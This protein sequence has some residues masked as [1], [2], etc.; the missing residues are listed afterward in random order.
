V[1][2]LFALALYAGRVIPVALAH[3]DR[4]NPDA[5]SYVRHALY[6]AQGRFADA[7]SGY[8][9]PL[10]SWTIA[11]L[12]ALGMDGLHAAH[13]VV[14][15]A[16][17]LVVVFSHL[18]IRRATHLGPGWTLLALLI[19]AEG[20]VR[21]GEA[22]FPDVLLAAGLLAVTALLAGEDLMERRLRPFLA[23]VV[24]GL[25]YLA[26]AYALPFFL[27]LL[28]LTILWRR[29]TAPARAGVT[30]RAAMATLLMGLA[31]FLVISAPWIGVLSWK[32]R[33]PTFS[34]VGSINHAIV[35][36]PDVA[37]E[38][39]NTS[40]LW[41][42]PPGRIAIW[43]TPE[44]M[45]YQPWSPFE[46]RAYLGHQ[47]A[48][49]WQAAREMRAAVGR[50][51]YLSLSLVLPLLAPFLILSWRDPDSAA[52]AGWLAATGMLFASGLTL[53]YFSYRYIDPF[54]R[55]L[56]VV[57]VLQVVSMACGRV[58][59]A[60]GAVRSGQTRKALSLALLGL[61]VFSYAAHANVPFRPFTLENPG[62][63]EFDNVVVDSALHRHLASE[64]EAGGLEGPLAS[65]L[66][67]GGLYLAFYLDETYLGTPAAGELE[68]VL[69]E[70]DAHGARS[71]LVDETWRWAR[72]L[73]QNNKWRLR[74]ALEPVPGQR[75]E[76]YTRLP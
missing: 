35:G 74:H 58:R 56:C 10:L 69:Q 18:L 29:W 26:K 51:D 27:A 55:P 42:P 2:L 40:R 46:S 67:W 21:W 37:R 12:M 68:A 48:N 14:A 73:R 76:I 49:I 36:P 31:G 65:T 57:M 63:T 60:D 22:V 72:A 3:R 25:A 33:Q 45:S 75:V 52:S 17:G 20:T 1:A 5:V 13:L 34:L 70:L 24:G 64:L 8:W 44:T 15:V 62:G 71:L 9:S 50:Y 59:H 23:G 66:H 19:I 54:L 16:G 53:V 43:E 61:V 30:T 38:H 39:P 4:I 28:V 47:V 6:L 11:P 32:Y 41:T 7:A